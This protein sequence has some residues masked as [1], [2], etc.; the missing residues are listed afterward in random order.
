MSGGP[1][2]WPRALRLA[3]GAGGACLLAGLYG[4]GCQVLNADH[5]IVLPEPRT[6]GERALEGLLA[7]RR[8][9]RDFA[10]TALGLAEAGQ[11][12]WAAQGITDPRGLRTAPSAG[13][14]YPL[15]VLLVAGRVDGVEPGVYRYLPASHALGAVAGSDRRA[16]LAVAAAGQ[17][18]LAD[19]PVVFVIAADY[20]RTARKYGERAG[21]YVPLEAGHAGQNLLLQAQALGLAAVV[22]GAF[23]DA[24]VARVLE[25]EEGLTPLALIA[26]GHRR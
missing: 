7:Q 5:T 11:L 24:A 6:R 9:V 2:P 20:A 3:R 17:S 8:S 1:R 19:A 12:L 25:L 22:V 21:R 13:A 15:E 26:V 16:A 18:W 14:L 23:G 4:G 10:D